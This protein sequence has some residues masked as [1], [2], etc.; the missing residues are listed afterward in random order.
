MIEYDIFEKEN[1][2][3]GNKTWYNLLNVNMY[4]YYY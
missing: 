1:Y 4:H 3:Q 2:I